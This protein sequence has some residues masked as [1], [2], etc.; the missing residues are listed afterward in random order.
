[1][2]G[3]RERF[4]NFINRSNGPGSASENLEANVVGPEEIQNHAVTVDNFNRAAGEVFI[5]VFLA[6]GRH[7]RINP[8]DLFTQAG[9]PGGLFAVIRDEY[10]QL[11]VSMTFELD[12]IEDDGE[13]VITN[14]FNDIIST[15]AYSRAKRP[16]SAGDEFDGLIGIEARRRGSTRIAEI[17]LTQFLDLLRKI[18][19]EHGKISDVWVPQMIEVGYEGTW[20]YIVGE[21]PRFLTYCYKV[22]DET[23]DSQGMVYEE[24]PIL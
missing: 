21:D 11:Q 2:E 20:T 10:G 3:L 22:T 23:T 8:T 15:Y 4:R 1:M 19:A 13:S 17:P 18:G 5:Y 9:L 24:Q 14:P 12:M 7:V 16:S 6:D